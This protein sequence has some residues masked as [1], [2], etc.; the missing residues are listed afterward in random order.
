MSDTPEEINV[1]GP[2]GVGFS[3]KGAQMFPVILVVLF[4]AF[5]AFLFYQGDLRSA[6]RDKVTEVAIASVREANVKAI[7]EVTEA[8][9]RTDRTLKTMIYVLS[10]PQS[11][12]ERLNLLRP[13]GLREMQR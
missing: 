7:S 5:S 4:G 9:N 11:E 8:T 10:L 12:R 1:S 3:F 13:E 6:E 2:G